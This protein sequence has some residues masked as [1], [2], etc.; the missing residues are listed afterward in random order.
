MRG[1]EGMSTNLGKLKIK[2]DT[3]KVYVPDDD[4]ARL[5][6]Y[7][8]CV[9][10]VLNYNGFSRYTDYKNYTKMLYSYE[11][12]SKI[13]ELAEKFNPTVMM[14]AGIFIINENTG[15]LDNRFFEISDERLNLHAFKEILIGG[16]HTKILNCKEIVVGGIR[17]RVLNIMFLKSSWLVRNYYMPFKRLTEFDIQSCSESDY[18]NDYNKESVKSSICLIF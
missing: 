14:K 3:H 2:D 11:G 5:M 8:D 1:I 7:L 4:L 16:K 10:T 17:T 13:L 15:N 12:Y 6:Y 9:F 18:D